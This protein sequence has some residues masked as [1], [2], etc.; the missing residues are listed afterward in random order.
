MITYE[1]TVAWAEQKFGKDNYIVFKTA[2]EFFDHVKEKSEKRNISDS[3][4][5]EPPKS[6]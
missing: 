2:K 1:Q 5:S 4:I 6:S 3:V